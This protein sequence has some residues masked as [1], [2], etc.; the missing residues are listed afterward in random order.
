MRLGERKNLPGILI[1]YV[2]FARR[3]VA[4]EATIN[5]ASADGPPTW[6]DCEPIRIITCMNLRAAS[7]LIYCPLQARKAVRGQA[8]GDSRSAMQ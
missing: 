7:W 2:P 4:A 5:I 6:E 1:T 8:L 3:Y